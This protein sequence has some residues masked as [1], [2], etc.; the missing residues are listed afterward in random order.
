ML[1]AKLIFFINEFLFN[2]VFEHLVLSNFLIEENFEKLQW[3]FL[4]QLIVHLSL[5]RLNDVALFKP[6]VV[7]QLII[8]RCVCSTESPL[9]RNYGVLLLYQSLGG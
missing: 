1:P 6:C 8:A 3:V 7:G 5:M 9:V 2:L 4:C